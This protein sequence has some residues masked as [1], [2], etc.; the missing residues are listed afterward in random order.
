MKKMYL[1]SGANKIMN[2]NKNIK[3][4]LFAHDKPQK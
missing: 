2:S 1:V 3:N 4:L